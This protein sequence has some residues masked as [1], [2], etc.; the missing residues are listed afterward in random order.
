MS[1]S[2]QWT[3]DLSRCPCGKGK[4]LEHV[5]SPDNPWSKPSRIVKIACDVC[6]KKWEI[7][8]MRLINRDANAES[9][10][11][12]KLYC[13]AGRELEHLVRMAIDSILSTRKLALPK[14]EWKFLKEAGLCRVGPIRYKRMRLEGR[15]ASAMCTA[16]HNIDW[17][18]EQ[19][20]GSG[21]REQIN[22]IIAKKGGLAAERA[23]SIL[24]LTPIN[25]NA[26][27]ETPQTWSILSQ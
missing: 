24:K 1:T 2:E 26:L 11:L 5:D 27:P 10:R 21:L 20:V 13:D 6:A 15:S 3:H 22:Q 4:I 14:E 16:K 18:L 23:A 19:I 25:L 17:I 9:Q 8:G 7:D 12:W